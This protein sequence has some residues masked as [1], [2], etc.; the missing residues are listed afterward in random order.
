M[1]PKSTH[2]YHRKNLAENWDTPNT[3]IF[4]SEVAASIL[5]IYENCI[6]LVKRKG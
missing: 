2:I 3:G 5:F 1:I 6:S 4:Y